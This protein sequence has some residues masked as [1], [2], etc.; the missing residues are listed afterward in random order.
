MFERYTEKARR[1]IFF[2][3]YEASQFGSPYIETEHLLLGLLREDK[4]L[5]SVSCARM[6]RWSPSASRSKGT[7]R[8]ARRSRPRWTCPSA[9][10]A[11]GYWPMRR[12]RRSA[13]RTSTLARSICCWDCC[14]KRSAL[15]PRFCMSADYALRPFA[16]SWRAAR[17][18]R[19]SPSASA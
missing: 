4:G 11:S 1:V 19:L 9:T 16:K 13:C 7:P 2:A 10:S 12:K 15:P 6:P 14:V 3:R 8:S 5:N 17:R 18:K